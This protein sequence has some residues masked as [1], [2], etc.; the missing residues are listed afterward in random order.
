MI[1]PST[2]LDPVHRRFIH[3]HYDKSLE[4]IEVDDLAGVRLRLPRII[5]SLCRRRVSWQADL[6]TYA[7]AILAVVFGREYTAER[8]QLVQKAAYAALLYLCNP[9]DLIPDF[10]PGI[11]YVDDA[12]VINR[13]LAVIRKNDRRAFEEICE[14]AGNS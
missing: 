11:G 7:E 9:Y 8:D 14:R 1:R 6:G 3:E 5:D 13:C 2:Q 10:T 12:L 4:T